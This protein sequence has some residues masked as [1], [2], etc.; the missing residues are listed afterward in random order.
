MSTRAHN[1]RSWRL[2][3][4]TLAVGIG[5]AFVALWSDD[6][7]LL[8]VT[9]LAVFLQ[10]CWIHRLYTTAHEAVHQKLIVGDPAWND[11]VGQALLLPLVTPLRV[12]RK[13]HRFHHGFNRRDAHTS[14]LDTFVVDHPDSPVVR[15]ACYAVWFVA[16]FLGGFFVHSLVS[17]LLFLALPLSVAQRVSP[18]FKGWTRADQLVSIGTFLLGVAVHLSVVAWLGVH[19]W[20]LVLG[21]PFVVFAWVYS[22]LVYIYHY[23]TPLG[24]DLQANARSL[25]HNPVFSWWLLNFNEH[26][27]HH[28][29]PTLP[30]YELPTRRIEPTSGPTTILGA[31]LAQLRG[32]SVVGRT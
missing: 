26:A 18:A 30:W 23:A 27:T 8:P 20:A 10:G 7:G 5:I 11:I 12:Y 9:A 31:V 13:I 21:W 32:P 1:S 14:A 28:A 29:H 2:V 19:G 16:V 24:G 25:R 15:A 6:R 3:F 4:E 17:V 22:M